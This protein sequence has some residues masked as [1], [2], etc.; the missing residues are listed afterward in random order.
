MIRL[1]RSSGILVP[2][3]LPLPRS[4]RVRCV[5]AA[6]PPLRPLSHQERRDRI[7]S[8]MIFFS[9]PPPHLS[10][11]GA[12]T[13]FGRPLSFAHVRARLMGPDSRAGPSHIYNTSRAVVYRLPDRP[14]LL[15]DLSRPALL[16]PQ[17]S[18]LPSFRPRVRRPPSPL[19]ATNPG[20]SPRSRC[21][22]LPTPYARESS[23]TRAT[24]RAPKTTRK[25][26]A[27]SPYLSTPTTKPVLVSPCSPTAP[28]CL[29]SWRYPRFPNSC[30]QFRSW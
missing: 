20:S 26:M 25:R 27:P 11:I 9:P 8:P 24:Q 19:V 2:Q 7:I 23:P 22:L 28:S 5:L 3:L 4:S 30:S 16:P 6:F 17:W 14:Y 12:V 10:Q 29:A 1:H 15:L 21:P 18:S 13:R